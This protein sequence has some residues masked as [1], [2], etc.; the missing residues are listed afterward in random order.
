MLARQGFS[1][2]ELILNWD[3]IVGPRLAANSR[4]I[5]LQWPPRPPSRAPD[6][7]AP[8]ATLVIRVE[9]AFALDLQHRADQLLAR[10]NG[11]FGWRCIGKLAFRQGPLGHTPKRRARGQPPSP[12]VLA[13]AAAQVGAV[14]D[15]ALRT[16]LARLGAHILSPR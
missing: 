1:E 3:D 16:A 4:P 10:I 15:D 5:K 9:G 14:E 2:S 7:P 11:H 8:T 13:A 6:A 12:A